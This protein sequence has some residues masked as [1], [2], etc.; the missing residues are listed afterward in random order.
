[1]NASLAAMALLL[2]GMGGLHCVGMCGGFTTA[3]AYGHS[4]MPWKGLGLYQG[5]RV[6]GYVALGLVVGLAGESLSAVGGMTAQR[7]LAVGAGMV[8]FGFGLSLL[9]WLPERWMTF[10]GAGGIWFRIGEKVRRLR[11]RSGMTGWFLLGLLNS[12]LPCGLVY[13]ALAMALGAANLADASLVMFFFGL[14]TVPAMMLT[15][16]ILRTVLP[17][18]RLRLVRLG[19]IALIA[20]GAL[21]IWRGWAMASHMHGAMPMHGG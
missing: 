15:P 9:G 7:A 1:M 2:G 8:M 4:S 18:W 17:V 10:A 14:G 11:Q 6:F 3:L 13:A 12:A 5:G 16:W 21:T 19:G 20:M